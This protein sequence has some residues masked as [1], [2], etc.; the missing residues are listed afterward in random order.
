MAQLGHDLGLDLADALPGHPVDLADFVEGL[1]LAV[2]QAE[3][4]RDHPS[5]AF[6]QSVEDG[7]QLLLEQSEAD[8]LTGLDRLGVLDQVAELAVA[9][10][11]ERCLLY[12]SDAADE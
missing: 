4:H 7:V 5:L 9:V 3:P 1:G 12:T 8:R 11:T 2:G 6:G 10:L